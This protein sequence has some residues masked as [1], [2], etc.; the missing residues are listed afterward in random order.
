MAL[1]IFSQRSKNQKLTLLI[2][3][4]SSSVGAALVSLEKGRPVHIVASVREDI[5][6]QEV[7][8]SARFLFVMNHSLDKVLKKIQA[9]LHST[10][11]TKAGS[12]EGESNM[13]E[14]VFCI[15][16]SPWFILKNR[17]IRVTRPSEFEVTSQM[18]DGFISDDVLSLKDE[19]KK[20]LPSS[21]VMIIEKKVLQMKLNG[22]EIKNPY[23]Q[24]T[25]KM[26]ISAIVGVSSKKVT[27]SIEHKLRNFFHIPAVHFGTFPIAAFSAVRDIFPAEKNFI[28]LDVTGEATDV[29]LVNNDL[30]SGTSSFSRGRNF[31]IREISTKLNTVHE[32]AA[33]L[34]AMY[35]RSELDSV[36]HTQIEAII[37]HAEGEWLSRFEKTIT[38]LTESKIFP[39]KIFFTADTDI[40]PLLLNLIA[41]SKT[42]FSSGTTFNAQYL[43]QLIISKFVSF[44][45]GV[46]RDPFVVIEALFAEKLV[47]QH[48][49]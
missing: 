44:E 3:I 31:F 22:Y 8:S 29:S 43:D 18:L 34:F 42:H 13:I 6:F 28:F 38:A 48:T 15:L 39:R 26:E 49:S 24:K 35:L 4:G 27:D 36:R 33:T 11:G 12:S 17:Q 46:T 45:T 25:S 20:T 10:S 19:L 41:K 1:S 30:L 21:D 40:A 14:Q 7:L 23:G 32:E 5:S 9:H 16:S 47:T 37:V 2:D